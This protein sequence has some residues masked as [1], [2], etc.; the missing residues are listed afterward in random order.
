MYLTLQT[1]TKLQKVPNQDYKKSVHICLSKSFN[2]KN[3]TKFFQKKI[4]KSEIPNRR[5]WKE[6]FDMTDNEKEDTLTFNMKNR[7]IFRP[8][9]S[10][11]LTGNEIIT[12]IHPLISVI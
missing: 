3:I 5:E 2:I 9:L 10:N 12:T 7:F 6:K 1:K 11:G 8:D 4:T